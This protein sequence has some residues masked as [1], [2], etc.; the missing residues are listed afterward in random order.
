MPVLSKLSKITVVVVDIIYCGVIVKATNPDG[1]HYYFA[2]ELWPQ[3]AKQNTRPVDDKPTPMKWPDR[4]NVVKAEA[5]AYWVAPIMNNANG[6]RKGGAFALA[7]LGLRP[8]GKDVGIWIG[9]VL[10]I[11]ILD[12]TDFNTQVMV[13]H[14]EA[15]PFKAFACATASPQF[16]VDTYIICRHK[17]K[18]YIRVI[19]R[20]AAPGP[21][22]P[23]GYAT[24]GGFLNGGMTVEA[25]RASELSEEGGIIIGD[26]RIIVI[27]LGER[28]TPGREPRYM[29]FSYLN[30]SGELITFG[31]ERGS[32]ADAVI[33][34]VIP[35]DKTQLPRLAKATDEAEVVNGEWVPVDEFLSWSNDPTAPE[36]YVPWIDHQAGARDAVAKLTE[37]GLI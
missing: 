2:I 16:A 12:N 10:E 3:N 29:P 5:E 25:G 32:T 31:C 26:N 7:N 36:H 28:N 35:K 9:S 30:A 23:E 22:Y 6:T 8:K 21:D 27:E 13:R 4:S 33:H 14:G 18:L 19:K 17:G 15:E 34:F 20:A 24:I 1:S 37:I 11:E